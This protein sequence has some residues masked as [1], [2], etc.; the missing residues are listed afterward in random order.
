MKIRVIL[1]NKKL[2]AKFVFYKLNQHF[3]IKQLNCP[4]AILYIRNRSKK[5]LSL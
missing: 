2:A 1:N 5:A 4:A 3:V